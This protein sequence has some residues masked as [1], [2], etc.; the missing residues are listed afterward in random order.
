MMSGRRKTLREKYNELIKENKKLKREFEFANY[1]LRKE[2]GINKRLRFEKQETEYLLHASISLIND[3]NNDL[4][5]KI[6]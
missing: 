5:N 2:Q 3:S 4:N 6:V 1:L